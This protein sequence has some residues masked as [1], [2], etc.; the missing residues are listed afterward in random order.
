MTNRNRFKFPMLPTVQIQPEP[1]NVLPCTHIERHG[2][3]LSGSREGMLGQFMVHPLVC[4]LAR[5]MGDF[6]YDLGLRITQL[7]WV[8]LSKFGRF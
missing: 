3:S 4:C 1:I 8:A 2:Y 5:V 6:D 7:H